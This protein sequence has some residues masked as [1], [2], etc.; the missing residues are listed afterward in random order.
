MPVS[1]LTRRGIRVKP[2]G[3]AVINEL[4]DWI[5]SIGGVISVERNNERVDSGEEH[6]AP[7]DQALNQ[8]A[9][10]EPSRLFTIIKVFCG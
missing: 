3:H 10:S 9:T 6:C 4:H 5:Q 1:K 2:P 8:C 7:R